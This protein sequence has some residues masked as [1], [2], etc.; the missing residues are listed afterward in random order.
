MSKGEEFR[1]KSFKATKQLGQ[2][3]KEYYQDLDQAA[4]NPIEKVAWCTSVGPAEL[5]LAL[6]FRVYY[7]E[8]HGAILGTSR[9]ANTYIPQAHAIGY[10]PDICSYLTSD[11][12][13][14]LSNA[15]PLLRAY[16]I[17]SVPK[18][19]V[20]V[21]NT[22]QCRD[23]QEWFYYYSQ[24]LGVPSI[25]ITSPR[26]LDEVGNSHINDVADQLR[27][28]KDELETQFKISFDMN[29]LKQHLTNSLEASKLWKAVLDTAM[30]SPS[31][32]T[33]FDCCIQMAP[34]VCF[35]GERRG[36]DYYKLLLAELED[37]LSKGIGAIDNERFRIYWEGMPI[38]GRIRKLAS[39]FME[40][41]SCLV[42]STYCN[43]WIIDALDPN[44]PFES[45]GKAYSEIFINRSESRK[46]T[47]IIDHVKRFNI[48]GVIF[49][50]SKTCPSNSNTRYGMPRRIQ[51]NYEI[52][53][54]VLD[55]DISDLS[56]YS[57]EQAI[58]NIEAFIEQ[59]EGV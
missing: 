6:G 40:L 48:D 10:S 42:A 1:P 25:G 49:H 30:N 55:G 20:L 26:A 28:M 13:A 58:T 3:M 7:P 36:I 53:T 35:R 15:T 31:P 5:L 57:E 38:W 45:M 50:N 8:N 21:Y 46:E 4:K 56:F 47:Y 43:S 19:D 59:L 11:I 34:A 9:T 2:R 41:N 18:P 12:G 29:Q 27:N 32:I 14:F 23:V 24:K 37:R 52:P 44:Q 39:L 51:E 17:D 54:L 33:F 22:N 16:G